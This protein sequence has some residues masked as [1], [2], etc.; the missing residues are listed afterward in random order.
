MYTK[1][2][3][4][5][6]KYDPV[7]SL[8]YMVAGFLFFNW[9]ICFASEGI[10]NTSIRTLWI[11]TMFSFLL[12]LLAV[13]IFSKLFIEPYINRRRIRNEQASNSAKI[14]EEV[15]AIFD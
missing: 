13:I 1:T 15:E 2:R 11:F 10:S 14:I 12:I 7:S 5:P 4:A 6:F 9:V 8:F 3:E